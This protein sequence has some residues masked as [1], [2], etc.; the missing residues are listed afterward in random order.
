MRPHRNPG[1]SKLRLMFITHDLALGGLQQVI[2]NICKTLNRNMFEPQVLCLRATGD[3]A[4]EIERLGIKVILLPQKEKGADYLAFLKV[5]KV[6]KKERIDVIHTHNTQPFID[7]VV[8]AI[9]AGVR[10]R[11]HTDHARDFPDKRRYM[12]AEWFLSHFV[13]KVVAVSDH[14]AENL[15]KYEK[16]SPRKICVIPNGIDGNRYA[17]T[18]DKD[19]KR[20]ELGIT[21][22]GPIIG[23]GVR[24]CEQK[25]ITYLLH[26]MPGIIEKIPDCT[27]VI[28]GRGPLEADL[29]NATSA[30]GI[31]KNVKFVGMRLDI[32]ELLK[33]F[34][35]Y[36]LPSLW[37]GL[38][39]V[40]LEAMAA[41]CPVVATDV[42]GVAT[43]VQHEVTGLIIKTK[44]PD[45]IRDAVCTVLSNGVLRESLIENGRRLFEREFDAKVMTGRYQALYV[46]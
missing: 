5:A 22:K 40:L 26:A 37:E 29:K 16:M 3:Y 6:L 17:I 25:G 45:E 46:Q 41:G 38:P 2:V 31:D 4:P 42:G 34:D 44:N 8:G 28:A 20:A 21:N 19:K 36:V 10:I 23:I 39:M 18:I 30:L 9:L 27:L 35:A 15:R 7:G 1:G 11:I 24:L 12:F 13:Y 43:V 32:P 14:T 33:L